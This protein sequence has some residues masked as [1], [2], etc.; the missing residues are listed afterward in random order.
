MRRTLPVT[1]RILQIVLSEQNFLGDL[2]ASI[3]DEAL[4]A[5][6][7]LLQNDFGGGSIK[8]GPVTTRQPTQHLHQ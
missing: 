6:L 4:D 2:P 1:D 7:E 5:L 8:S 3:V